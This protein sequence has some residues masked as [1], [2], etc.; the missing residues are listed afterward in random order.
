MCIRILL[1]PNL[2]HV[3][4]FCL[5]NVESSFCSAGNANFSCQSGSSGY[6]IEKSC[7]SIHSEK[8]S[9]GLKKQEKCS[10]NK[11]TD[12]LPTQPKWKLA[13]WWHNYEMVGISCCNIHVSTLLQTDK[14][15]ELLQELCRH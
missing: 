5:P 10:H 4:H 14:S 11:F 8:F 7:H 13:E 1:Q 9:L 12:D 6:Y 15:Y 3:S 2:Y